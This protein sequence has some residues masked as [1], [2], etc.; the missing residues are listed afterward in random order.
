VRISSEVC[1]GLTDSLSVSKLFALAFLLLLPIRMWQQ[2]VAAAEK[3]PPMCEA[4][5]RERVQ[6]ERVQL[7]LVQSQKPKERVE[8]PRSHLVPEKKDPKVKETTSKGAEK[9]VANTKL[10]EAPPRAET[11]RPKNPS[12]EEPSSKI[13]QPKPSS[14]EASSKPGGQK[15]EATPADAPQ[16]HTSGIGMH[17]IHIPVDNMLEGSPSLITSHGMPHPLMTSLSKQFTG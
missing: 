9:D 17:Y 1:R 13:T 2:S 11:G 10:R 3:L 14:T 6:S 8:G 16:P 12:S 4:A 7:E 5:Q 15:P